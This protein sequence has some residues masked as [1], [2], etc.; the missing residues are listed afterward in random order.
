MKGELAEKKRSQLKQGGAG[1][2]TIKHVWKPK[3]G[4]VGKFEKIKQPNGKD[5]IY[6]YDDREDHRI[7]KKRDPTY[8]QRKIYRDIINENI[9]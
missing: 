1:G 3:Q 4:L 2:G 8:P 6:K 9:L 7:L 5:Q